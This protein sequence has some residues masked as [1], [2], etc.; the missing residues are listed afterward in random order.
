MGR[1]GVGDCREGWGGGLQGVERGVALSVTV[2]I[3][4]Q[5]TEMWKQMGVRRK[6]ERLRGGGGREGGAEREGDRG[7]VGERD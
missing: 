7:G 3:S 6:K 2:T 1:C 4:R 5:R